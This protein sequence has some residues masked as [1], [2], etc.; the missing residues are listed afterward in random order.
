MVILKREGERERGE[1]GGDKGKREKH[2]E[3]KT[4]S[5]ERKKIIENY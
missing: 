3:E 2:R 4:G 1:E 5:R